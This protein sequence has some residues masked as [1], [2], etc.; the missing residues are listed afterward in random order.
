[1]QATNV[2]GLFQ[3]ALQ[4]AESRAAELGREFGA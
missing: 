4:A 1:M 3:Q 2:K